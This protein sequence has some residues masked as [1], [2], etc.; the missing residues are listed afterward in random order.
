MG[1]EDYREIVATCATITSMGQMLSGTLMC[2]DIYKKGSSKDVDPMPFLGGIG[3]C[4]LMLQYAWILKDPGMINI[5][6]FGVLVNTAYMAVYYYYSTHTK[7]TLVLLGK[8]AAFVSVFLLYAQMENSEKIEFR[9][10]IIVTTLFLLL[11]ASPLIHLGE[12]IRTQNTDILPFPLIFMGTL[13][14]FQ[15]LLYGLIINNS[16]VIFQNVIGCL[17]SVVQMSLFVIYPSKSKAKID[18]QE[19]MD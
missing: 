12:V 7:D 1:L 18:R 10:G 13:A 15:W 14:S 16:F 3:M 2:K 19:K 8:T 5:N 9:F 11:I 6:V 4:I 17:L